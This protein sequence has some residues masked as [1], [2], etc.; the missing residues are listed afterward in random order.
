MKEQFARQIVT[1]GQR[2][3]AEL[4]LDDDYQGRG[5]SQPTFGVTGSI[6]DMLQGVA[7][8]ALEVPEED[9]S[10]FIAAVGNVSTD[11]MHRATIF[12]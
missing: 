2:V 8:A 10:D 6:A 4:T 11:S 12:Y 3:G 9:R 1:S 5:R 7:A